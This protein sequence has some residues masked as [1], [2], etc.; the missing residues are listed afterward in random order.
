MCCGGGGLCKWLVDFLRQVCQSVVTGAGW[1]KITSPGNHQVSW[2]KSLINTVKCPLEAPHLHTHR[3]STRK[4]SLTK[5]GLEL[6]IYCWMFQWTTIW[7]LVGT[8]D[9]ACLDVCVSDVGGLW[10]RRGFSWLVITQTPN[11]IV[12][13]V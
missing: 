9:S 11:C 2:A 12:S 6:T 1:E 8:T 3:T 10:S 4:S 5:M 7:E 13:A